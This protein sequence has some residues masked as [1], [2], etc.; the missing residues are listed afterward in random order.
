LK[1]I[2]AVSRAIR[3]AAYVRESPVAA[4]LNS[5]VK[6]ILKKNVL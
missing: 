6:I 2:T 5:V 4:R 1:V 3:G